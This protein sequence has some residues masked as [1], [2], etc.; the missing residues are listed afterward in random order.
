[1]LTSPSFQPI[2]SVA[3]GLKRL[4]PICL[5][6]FL[7]VVNAGGAIASPSVS[8]PPSVGPG[9]G[10]LL[11]LAWPGYDWVTDFEKETSCQVSVKTVATSDE[12][13]TL[14]NQGRYDLVTASGDATRRLIAGN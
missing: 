4:L 8:P 5:S 2:H 11:I 9:E 13:V 10:E 12:M 1:M 6:L 7:L 14:M 3:L